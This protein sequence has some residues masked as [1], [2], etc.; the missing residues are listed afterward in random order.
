MVNQPDEFRI[1]FKICAFNY[2]EKWTFFATSF[3]VE[4][5]LYMLK[6]VPYRKLRSVFIIYSL[7]FVDFRLAWLGFVKISLFA[8]TTLGSVEF[9]LGGNFQRFF[10]SY[11]KSITG[12]VKYFKAENFF[13]SV[14]KEQ[15]VKKYEV[16]F[17]NNCWQIRLMKAVKPS[18]N[19]FRD[20]DFSLNLA[21]LYIC[22]SIACF[23][24][25]LLLLLFVFF[26]K[27]KAI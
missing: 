23:F 8:Y 4:K 3:S 20:K 2:L 22:T 13:L 26:G 17:V 11:F 21:D 14:F 10:P 25:N 1:D 6:K 16:L 5:L 18:F 9:Y 19:E 27:K 7:C 24:I 15:T 12:I